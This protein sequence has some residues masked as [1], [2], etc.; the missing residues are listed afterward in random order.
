MALTRIQ[1]Y[2]MDDAGQTP[3]KPIPG[4]FYDLDKNAYYNFSACDQHLNWDNACAYFMIALLFGCVDSMCKN[5]TIRSWGTDVWYCCFYD[6]D[7]AFGLNNAGQDIVEYWAHLHR[8]YNIAS[9]DTGITQYTQEKNYVST[10][11]YKQYFA[12][13]WNRIWEVL[14]NLAGIDS[15]STENRTSLESLYVN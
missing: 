9:Q 8:W 6:M 7:T 1:K 3:T 14:E 2:T 13:W 10:D 11:S 5:L 4:E 15:G 12:S